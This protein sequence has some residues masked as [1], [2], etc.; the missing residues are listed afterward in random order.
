MVRQASEGRGGAGAK[1][2]GIFARSARKAGGCPVA[3][4]ANKGLLIKKDGLGKGCYFAFPPMATRIMSGR[5]AARFGRS[6]RCCTLQCHT[7]TGFFP[8]LAGRTS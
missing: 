5:A 3:S 4:Q 7:T 2:G 1:T 6:A 8:W